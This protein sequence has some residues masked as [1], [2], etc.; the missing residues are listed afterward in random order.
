MFSKVLGVLALLV[1]T[2]ALS[3][4]SFLDREPLAGCR[5]SYSY[6]PTTVDLRAA[7]GTLNLVFRN[8]DV[9]KC[10]TLR[11]FDA[12]S[13]RTIRTYDVRSAGSNPSYTISR[14]QMGHLSSDCS[15][16]FTLSGGYY[17]E[18]RYVTLGWCAPV[19]SYP[20]Y[21]TYPSYDRVTYEWSREGNCKKMINGQYSGQNV[22][23]SYCGY[24]Q[25]SYPSYP[26]S[27]V[28]YEWS[29]KGHCKKMINGQYSGENVA[30]YNCRR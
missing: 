8:L 1:S 2:T 14:E 10:G 30:E 17:P 20:T 5:P 25:P 4:S 15:L 13:G 28:T 6:Q 7:N 12:S 21:P 11:V 16:G 22:S 29:N 9:N 26:R 3:Y 27:N 23:D 24:R 18:T 19:Y